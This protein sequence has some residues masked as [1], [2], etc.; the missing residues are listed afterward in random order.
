MA[1]GGGCKRKKI[2]TLAELGLIEPCK[3]GFYYR[4]YK[5]KELKRSEKRIR[6]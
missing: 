5:E 6:G 2:P 3:V 1:N 4:E